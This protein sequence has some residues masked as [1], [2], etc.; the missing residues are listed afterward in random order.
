MSA[1]AIGG[2]RTKP[3]L[4][5]RPARAVALAAKPGQGPS[6]YD[7]VGIPVSLE[8]K[9]TPPWLAAKPE[10]SA[11]RLMT[12]PWHPSVLEPH[13]L[14]LGRL[15]AS[16]GIP[17]CGIPVSASQCRHPSV[18]IPVSASQCVGEQWETRIQHYPARRSAIP[19]RR[20]SQR[21]GRL[22]PPRLVH[23]SPGRWSSHT[24]R[25]P[26]SFSARTQGGAAHADHLH[27]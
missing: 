15:K 21:I 9:C 13:S 3:L 8:P 4:P 5:P 19:L 6:A 7:P 18:G 16:H 24:N 20:G 26:G 23:L 25:P 11:R 22:G 17:V 14:P 2:R 27:D 12:Q 1:K 10:A